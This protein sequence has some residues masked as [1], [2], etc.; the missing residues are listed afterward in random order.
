MCSYFLKTFIADIVV[1][2]DSDFNQIGCFVNFI[3]HNFVGS[4][5]DKLKVSLD[6][7]IPRDFC[8]VIF[9][10]LYWLVLGVSTM[11]CIPINQCSSSKRTWIYLQTL[12]WHSRYFVVERP[13]QPDMMWRVV[14]FLTR[15]IR[16]VSLSSTLKTC[17]L[18]YIVEITCSCITA[19]VE[20][21][22]LFRVE[23]FSH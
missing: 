16:H 19:T 13:S 9:N 8:W 3:H 1:I 23:D 12:S 6:W 22:G 10:Y 4:V 18:T 5:V 21:V 7:E 2:C 20:S 14:S 17:F 11:V 15:Q